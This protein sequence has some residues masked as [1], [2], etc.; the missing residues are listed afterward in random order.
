MSEVENEGGTVLSMDAGPMR[1]RWAASLLVTA[2]GGWQLYSHSSMGAGG[3]K[4]E[5][6]QIHRTKGGN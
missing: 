1:G 6:S 2:V 5:G 3:W 4:D